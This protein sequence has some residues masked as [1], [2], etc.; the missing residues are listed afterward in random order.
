MCSE[1]DSKRLWGNSDIFVSN[2][3]WIV[4]RI[5]FMITTGYEYLKAHNIINNKAKNI[6]NIRF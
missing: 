5:I 6:Y 3:T 1:L 4:S 2:I